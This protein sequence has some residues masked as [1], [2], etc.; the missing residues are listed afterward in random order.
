MSK[1]RENK[2][3][4]DSKNRDTTSTTAPSVP[5]ISLPKGGG[6]LRS[7]GEKF[8]AN[9]VNGTWSGNIPIAVSPGRSG[10]TPQLALSYDSG[11]G[12][13]P[14]G[15]GWQ[16]SLPSITRKTDKGLP[17]YDNT[18][19]DI[20]VLSGAEDLVPALIQDGNAWRPD[21]SERTVGANTYH[22]KR[23]R[24]RIEGLFARIERWTNTATSETHWRTISPDNITTFY[25]QKTESR[26]ADPADAS[27][28]FSWLI[29][30][31]RDDKGNA[32]VY[33]YVP[34]DSRAIDLASPQEQNRNDQTRSAN[35]YLKRV[36][37]SNQTSHL[38][39]P[40]LS[41]TDWL[42]EIVFDYGEHDAD[43]PTPNVT[44]PWPSR[45][46][47]FS[48]YRAGFEVRTYRLCRRVLMFH[49]FPDELGTP[50]YLVR[51]TDFNYNE[52]SL[53]SFLNAV[54]HSGYMRQNNGTYLKKS[55]PPLEFE[56]SEA[57]VQQEVHEIDLDS[58]ENLPSGI[59]DS[60]YQFVDLDG[61]GLAG[62]LTEQGGGWFYKPNLGDGRFG[63]LQPVAF[64]PSTADLN[65]DQ[66]L[67]DLAGDGQLDLVRFADSGSGFYERT[68]DGTW[69]DFKPF[70]STPNVDWNNS[71][72]R[73][74]D[75]TGDGHADILVTEDEVL[76][77]Y[78]SLAEEGFGPAEK[79]RQVL[80]E[81]K[82][83]HL[84]FSEPTQS[85]FV[86][87][88]SGDGLGDLVRIRNGEICYWPNLGYGKF[89]AKVNMANAPW[90]DAP[91]Q[92]DQRRLRLADIDGS[93]VTDIVYLKHDGINLYFNQ[94]GNSWNEVLR[95]DQL[96]TDNEISITIAD[97]L[98][99]GTACI[100]W[101]SA[102][103]G[104]SRQPMRYLKLMDQ[105]PHLLIAT[106]NNMGS[107]TR[108][109]YAA[110]TKFYLAD[111]ANG[112][113]WITKLPF[114]VHVV[115]SVETVDHISR[116]RF[117]SRYAYHHGYFDGE[118]REFRGFGMVEQFDT[119]S[120]ENFVSGVQNFDGVQESSAELFQPPVTTRTWFH[121]GIFVDRNAILSQFRDEYYLKQQHLQETELPQGLNSQE[122]RECVRALKGLPLRQEVYSFDGSAQ[123]QHPY[124]VTENSYEI[125]LVQP[126]AE[127][128]YAIFLPVGRE[129]VSFNYERNPADPRIAHSIQLELDEFGNP[130]KSC[131]VVY[132]RKI[133]AGSLPQEVT[134]DQQ[135]HYITYGETDYTADIGQTFAYRLRVA[136]ESRSYEIT[137]VTPANG[138]FTLDELKT[139]I[140][141]CAEIP[142]EVVADG[143]T[144]QKRLLSHGRTLFLDNNL[145][146]MPLGQWDSL[147]LSH[148]SFQLAFTPGV[149]S[150]QYDGKVTD[151]EF[152]AAGYVHF[153]GDNNWWTTSGTVI[154][155]ADPA[156]HFYIPIGSSDPL[157]LVTITTLDKYD[158][159]V[160][161]TQIKQAI[162]NETTVV[163]NYR[164]LTPVLIT[165]PNQ[166]RSTVEHDVLGMAMKFAVMGKSG[167][168]DGDTLADPTV[169]LEYDLFNWM[170]HRQP[171]FV[172]TFAR[173]QHG[174]ANPRWQESYSHFNGSCGVAMTKTQAHPGK[175]LRVDRDGSVIEV[176]ANPRWIGNGRTILNNKGNV[177]KQFEPYFSTTHEYEDESELR[178][179]GTTP[180]LFYDAVGRNIRTEFANGTLSKV[181]FGSWMQRS[182]D[183]NDTVRESQWYVDRGSPDPATESEPLNNPERRA[184]W[185]AA[186]HADTPVVVHYDSL[187]RAVYTISD[188]GA[189]K[190]AAVYSE[191]DL[192]GRLT[193]V[194]DQAKREVGSGFAGML[195]TPIVG[196]TAEKGRRWIFHNALG[197][198]VKTW[199]EHGRQ[200]RAEFDVLHRPVSVFVQENK[201]PEILVNH[202]LYG[203]RLDNAEQLNLLGVADQIFDQAG[204]LHVPEMDFKGNPKRVERVLAKDYKNNLDWTSVALA[205]DAQGVQ[206]ALKPVLESK[207]VFTASSEV[208]ALNRPTR[209]TLPDGTIVLPTY[210]EANVLASLQA[211]IRGKGKFVEFLKD[212]DYDAKGQR[213][214]AH[215]GNEV[216]CRYFYDP[217]TFKLT[218]LLTFK[219]D[220]DPATQSLQNLRYTYDPVG[221]VTQISDDA[222]QT[223]YFQNAVVK[224]ENLY[225][226]DALY[227]LIRATGRELAGLVNDNVRTDSD[228]NFIPQLPHVN[229]SNA[230]RTYTEEYVYDLLG[231][232]QTFK[233]RFKAL[234]GFG[235][236][237]TRNYR[238]AFQDDP[239][240]N[241]NRLTSSSLPGDPDSG[242]YSATYTYDAYGNMSRM[243]HLA[244]MQWNFMDQL[245]RVDLGGGGTA[246]YVYGMGGQ[247][248]RKVIERSGNINIETIFLGPVMILRR[249]RR[250]TEELRFERWT[251]NIS[252]NI[253]NIAQVDI[254]TR[255]DDNSDPANPLNVALI[256]YQYSNHLGSAVLETDDDGNVISYEE[257]HPYGSTSYRSAKPG[258]D[259][260]LK[261]YRFSGKERDDESGLYYFGV[262][263]YAS[264]LG[265]WTSS[266]PGGFVDGLNLFR[267]AANNPTNLTDPDGFAAVSRSQV[268][269]VDEQDFTGQES[270]EQLQ[271]I[272]VPEG[273]MVHP[274]FNESTYKDFY[275]PGN[276]KDGAGGIWAIFVEIPVEDFGDGNGSGES[277]HE[278]PDPPA[279]DPPAEEPPAD[280]PE[281]DIQEGAIAES[282]RR[283]LES[284]LEPKNIRGERAEGL[285]R[286]WSGAARQAVAAEAK[287]GKCFTMR[288]VGGNASVEHA[289]A[290]AAERIAKGGNYAKWLTK[291]EMK[292]IWGWRSFKFIFKA[293]F[294]G[295]GVEETGP[296]GTEF[297]KPGYI[298][299]KFERP[300]RRLGGAAAGALMIASGALTIYF[301]S[302]DPN[303]N[304]AKSLIASGA[305]EIIAGG[306][307]TAAQ[308]ASKAGKVAGYAARAGRLFGGIG[309][310]IGFGVEAGRSLE[311]KDY[312]GFAINSIGFLGGLA[313]AVSAFT[314]VGW[315]A[316]L[317][318]VGTA[319]ILGA[320]GA[321]IFRALRN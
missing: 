199:D 239:S 243:P 107:E 8:A 151:D 287:A 308:F 23:Y 14:F 264:W 134:R 66:H 57:K 61:E 260:S 288:N 227:Q 217:K 100:V 135:N 208:D 115:E 257:Y 32:I 245:R 161:R 54:T 105:K 309:A 149:T 316:I 16:L 242:P 113:P 94:S 190:I 124:T 127:Q 60:E 68:Q 202:T 11:E 64:K 163:N 185:L 34:E 150:I 52:T 38:V 51:S 182:F 117:V 147:G 22:I 317:A 99:D 210:N 6:A 271:A 284:A 272:P 92:F 230:V 168:T 281:A 88:M 101:S 46:D 195:G 33:E 87:D 67:M 90:F 144:R 3:Q 226:Y 17:R 179:I 55:F 76:T 167:S 229:D 30:E 96:P 169:R 256:R 207:E 139:S 248:L 303:P 181:E 142:Y 215:Y 222:Q 123:E 75:L 213:Q 164:L 235:G 65:S 26:I 106:K 5:S 140:A 269:H 158:L 311:E 252:D 295:H 31:S 313:L 130:L 53:A 9:P 27:R 186:K 231:N 183:V 42:F 263:Y 277:E 44:G 209:V 212:Q 177:V 39:Q 315:V 262:R 156:A 312:T 77:W 184:A 79:L 155:P 249:R 218:N 234:R 279:E 255:D 56:Y 93:G 297:G 197:A 71:D 84:V 283:T 21:V 160:E 250:D 162:W 203:D 194:F 188:Y 258:F 49:H 1:N 133:A 74:V 273:A 259:V 157:G 121:T 12:N 318:A 174:A 70:S 191:S 267:Y 319:L 241:T 13:G 310:M 289:A 136:H 298:Q 205:S 116:N 170:D 216:F 103:P 240:N 83:P 321:N 189:G 280:A 320:T 152:S 221:N 198:M 95:L 278:E 268:K 236:G 206:V 73:F 72:L 180:I 286:T 45:Q 196:E 138:L 225:E 201:Q 261:R 82:S 24:P 172:H 89:G 110:S 219:S 247:R 306:V 28:V 119:E 246:Y 314:P 175:A 20:F 85:I 126:Q 159:L 275:L 178:E 285:G 237:W 15:L 233:H 238:Y 193:R 145:N 153:N 266:D 200:F 108:V 294:S 228:L 304:V 165:D 143:T 109:K 187:G 224:P 69:F 41:H 62:I 171:N 141:G 91:D 176:D 112:K 18:D 2:F 104:H 211:Q 270:F 146:P 290:R 291:A 102:L 173:E 19:E 131:S 36:K 29:C 154:F 253:G 282:G 254:K 276:G 63:S 305:G 137:G 81:E 35:R 129:A 307:Y 302:Q 301:G 10:F 50:D 299:G 214:F 300:A 120:F 125:K 7:I 47:P 292:A 122:A 58:A 80:D 265:R 148:Q 43:N 220:N 59:N 293:A 118:E 128:K 78:P 132:G 37:Y 40:D 296:V 232:I 97:L 274:D 114:P 86:A 48:T 251:V 244:D 25:G 166:N 223:H 111:K 98:G 4:D 204:M 192:T